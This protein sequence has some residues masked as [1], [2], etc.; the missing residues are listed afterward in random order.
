MEVKDYVYY[1]ELNQVT[2]KNWYLFLRIDN[3]FDQ[4]DGGRVF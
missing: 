3:L 4:L 1:R 2:I